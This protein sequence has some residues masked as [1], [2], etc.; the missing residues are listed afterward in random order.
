MVHQ[1]Q[2]QMNT[3][4]TFYECVVSVVKTAMSD[5][6]TAIVPAAVTQTD[7]GAV[8]QTVE[9]AVQQSD[10]SYTAEVRT[11]NVRRRTATAL[12]VIQ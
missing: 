5:W 12:W 1:L 8:R 11:L 2:H 7:T 6:K 4:N 3:T 9:G 10:A